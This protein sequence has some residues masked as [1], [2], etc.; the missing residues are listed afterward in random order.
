MLNSELRLISL[1]PSATEILAA[2]G[3]T[4][5]IVGRSHECDY[6]TEI[7]HLPICTEPKFNPDGSSAEIHN[8]VTEI[9]QSALSVYQVKL[10]VLE[11]LKPTHIITQAQCEVCAVSL[12]DVEAAVTELTGC[13]PQIIS[14]QPNLLEDVFA[15][16]WRVATILN[17]SAQELIVQLKTRIKTCTEKIESISNLKTPKVACIE[18]TNPLMG[19]GNWIPELVKLAGGNPLFAEEGKHSAWLKWEEL[20]TA[21]PDVIIIMPCGY[22]LN[23]TRQ[24]ALQL[25]SYPEWEQLVA[26]QTN[27]VYI[28][29]GNAYFNRSGPRLVD[30][31][32]ILAEI[33]HP[34]L[35]SGN[36]QGQAW[37]RLE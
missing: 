23:R 35:F 32:E 10:E 8:R 36:D 29:D 11:Q 37:D 3:L 30:S 15:D 19:A 34:N 33:L 21:N 1:I 16:I 27:Q 22:D 17:V 6:P 13:Q 4:H 2:L 7:Q 24:D 20:L 12:E 5:A 18:W 31:L 25:K 26:V 28:T 14:L 9:L